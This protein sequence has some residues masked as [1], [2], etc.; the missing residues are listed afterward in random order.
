[1][2]SLN[3]MRA[4]RRGGEDG[5]LSVAFPVVV[6]TLLVVI[7]L[8]FDGGNGITAH[9][10][11]INIAEQAARAGAA[12]L[13]PTSMRGSG[14]YQIDP[15]IAHQAASAY[16]AAAG[17]PGQVSIGRDATGQYVAVTVRWQQPTVFGQL[18]GIHQF[19]GTGQ[20][21]AHACHGIVTLEGC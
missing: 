8:C 11:A 16:L 3:R 20:A 14:A 13:S 2:I 10:R 19:T 15:I 9:R 12:H 5:S 18:L 1:V 4:H 7:G 21:Q 6:A 17:Y